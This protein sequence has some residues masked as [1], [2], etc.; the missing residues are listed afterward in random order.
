M[1]TKEPLVADAARAAQSTA[2][3][4]FVHDAD[5]DGK[6]L[7]IEIAFF[8]SC[9][10][11]SLDVFFM[12]SQ[13]DRDGA[14]SDE[15]Q[16]MIADPGLSRGLFMHLTTFKERWQLSG[17]K[18]EQKRNDDRQLVTSLVPHLE[19]FSNE[20]ALQVISASRDLLIELDALAKSKMASGE[21]TEM[22]Y[23]AYMRSVTLYLKQKAAELQHK[24][25]LALIKTMQT[26]ARD[27]GDVE[28]FCH[29]FLNPK[30]VQDLYEKLKEMNVPEGKEALLVYNTGRRDY[31]LI[32]CKRDFTT[33]SKSDPYRILAINRGKDYK[34]KKKIFE[35]FPNDL[36][37]YC[38]W[39]IPFGRLRM[40][41]SVKDAR[42]KIEAKGV[43]S[44]V[45]GS[46]KD[47]LSRS[48]SDAQILGFV[49]A[50][51]RWSGIQS[52]KGS[53]ED[54]RNVFDGVDMVVALE[55]SKAYCDVR[56]EKGAQGI[57][58]IMAITHEDI[59]HE[60][61]G[62]VTGDFMETTCDLDNAIL[63][64]FLII[65]RK[66]QVIAQGLRKNGYSAAD[67][68]KK[69]SNRAIAIAY[70]N[71]KTNA[72]R[73]ART[74]STDGI[75]EGTVKYSES[76]EIAVDLLSADL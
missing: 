73:F 74:G 30:R 57:A 67:A 24:D 64:V 49:Y 41:Q 72:E 4:Y 19:K 47:P 75:P 34:G 21:L 52:A 54:V 2:D 44:L 46:G 10:P 8:E 5:L 50:E 53:D 61:P 14:S 65:D 45:L 69:L 55:D 76:Y 42:G 58:Q 28:T 43:E 40:L 60:Y 66:K 31:E 35:T 38:G 63:A 17:D 56:S 22:E 37:Q 11:F 32:V 29:K 15:I 13:V 59:A 20:T 23:S 68:I 25:F 36:R 39:L 9:D 1:S 7:P 26:E 62:L 6:L 12:M 51:K 16:K 27:C 18:L 48:I 33:D 70:N 71:N 3:M